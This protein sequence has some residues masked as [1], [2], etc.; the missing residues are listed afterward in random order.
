MGI[1]LRIGVMIFSSIIALYAILG[2]LLPRYGVIAG[3]DPYSQMN[4]FHE[5]LSRIVEDYV[6]E[7]NLEKVR[8]GALRGLAEGLDPYSAYLTPEQV[9]QFQAADSDR[10]ASCGMTIS[11]VAGYVYVVAVVKKGPADHAGVKAGDVLEYINNQPTRDMSLY[12]ALGLLKGPAGKEV[13][14]RV[15]RG[16]RSQT[17]KVKLAEFSPPEPTGK[18]LSPAIGYLQVASLQ[19]GQSVAIKNQ[20]RSLV[21]QG[22]KSLVLDLRGVADGKIEEA[23]A[24]ANLF[25]GQGVLAKLVGKEAKEIKSFEA[26]PERRIFKGALVAIIDRTTAGAAEAIAAA[27]LE[28][29]VGEVIGERTFGAGGEQELFRLRDGGG[30]LIT[31]KKYASPSGRPFLGSTSATSGVTPSVEVKIS[32]GPD[33]SAI[34]Q[35]QEEG[36]HSPGAGVSAPSPDSGEDLLL[37]KAIELLRQPKS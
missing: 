35:I 7:P 30:M 21:D 20:L 2:G 33:L 29:K 25:I 18:L 14:L 5:V 12:D 10:Q 19:K 22:I 13:E 1:K 4:I 23:V 24:V 3:N 15:F 34:E 16:G 37:K 32:S 31:T 6:D 8:I 27:I 26:Q 9:S 28:N 36:I 11:K 17:L